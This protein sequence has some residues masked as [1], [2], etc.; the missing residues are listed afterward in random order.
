[1]P[2]PVAVYKTLHSKQCA[3]FL[4]MCIMGMR[5]LYNICVFVF[6][7]QTYQR[8]YVTATHS[9]AARCREETTMQTKKAVN[10]FL[11][12]RKRVRVGG[13]GGG[14]RARRTRNSVTQVTLVTQPGGGGGGRPI[15]SLQGRT[16]CVEIA[17]SRGSGGPGTLEYKRQGV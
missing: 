15:I 5:H 12:P 3:H 1:M 2:I 4:H 16:H 7:S 13:G 10:V 11:P 9:R 8:K 6:T 14:E 17:G